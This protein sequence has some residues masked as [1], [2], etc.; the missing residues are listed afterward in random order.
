MS[1]SNNKKNRKDGVIQSNNQK[2][3]NPMTSS[4]TPTADLE[5]PDKQRS[6]SHATNNQ[7]LF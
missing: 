7:K 5:Y 3:P 2:Y 1:K 6:H 4:N